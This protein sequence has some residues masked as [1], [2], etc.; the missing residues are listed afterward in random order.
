LVV[1]RSAAKKALICGVSGQDG[2]YLAQLLLEKGYEVSGT[3]RDVLARRFEGLTALGIRDRVKL[4]SMAPNDF[5]S[6]M[7]VLKA[8]A[9]DEIYN[10]A[11]QT[12]VGLSFE[13]PVETMES[14]A[15]GTLNLLEAIR[16]QPKPVRFYQAGTSECF[17]DLADIAADET[18]PFRPC[19]PYAIA[20]SAAIWQVANYRGAYGLQ[21]C[22]G[23]LFNHESPL[24][25]ERFVTKKIVAA[26]C[27][28]AQGSG[29]KLTLGNIAIERDWGWAPEYVEAM[30]LMLQQDEP[31]DYVI[32]TGE[33]RSLEEF[34]DIAFTRVGLKW[35]DHVAHDPRLLRPTD[36]AVGRANP[37]KARCKLGWQAKLKLQDVVE[38]MVEAQLLGNGKEPVILDTTSVEG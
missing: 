38:M 27:R 12:S 35:R 19:S 29:E 2:A 1:N 3:S 22:S 24:R 23:I 36:F 9:P 30:W 28:I 6:V 4:V 16:F 26:A 7:C 32:A 14:I 15:I 21:A 10:L 5:H 18:T 11:G 25:P 34:I 33:T 8:V 13:Q 20:K 31:D 37:A 17:G